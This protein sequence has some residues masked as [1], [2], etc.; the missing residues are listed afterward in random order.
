MG[1]W[2]AEAEFMAQGCSQR[3]RHGGEAEEVATA[4]HG[5]SLIPLAIFDFG[6][7]LAEY[8]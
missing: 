2:A 7:I 3:Q 8:R 4:K 5:C 6:R 1:H